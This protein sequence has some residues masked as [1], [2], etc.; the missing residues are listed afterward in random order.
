MLDETVRL[1]GEIG[2]FAKVFGEWLNGPARMCCGRVELANGISRNFPGGSRQRVTN[3]GNRVRE[4]AATEEDLAVID[5][6]REAHRHVINSFQAIL[7]KRT[8]LRRG[9]SANELFSI[10]STVTRR[11]SLAA[12]MMWRG[13]G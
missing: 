10:N 13:V 7:R 2:P 4:H 1:S 6:W 11:C 12:W 5:T 3:A 8:H 9:I